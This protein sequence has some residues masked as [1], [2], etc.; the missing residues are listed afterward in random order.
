MK[1][2]ITLYRLAPNSRLQVAG[3]SLFTDAQGGL[4]KLRV[5]TL[6]APTPARPVTIDKKPFFEIKDGSEVFVTKEQAHTAKIAE[7]EA[8]GWAATLTYFRASGRQIII[9]VQQS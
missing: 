3:A 8:S 5:H 6:R 4:H 7:A 2:S 9:N 1:Q